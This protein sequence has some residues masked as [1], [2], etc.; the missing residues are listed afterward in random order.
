[1]T[2]EYEVRPVPSNL[3]L[4]TAAKS[5]EPGAW[6]YEID[7]DYPKEQVTPPEA[8]RGGW[9]V[10]QDG[11]LTGRYA[12]NA[13]YRAI[14]QSDRVLKPYMYVGARSFKSQWIVD[15]DPRGEHLFPAIPD[16]LIRGW[17]Y[18]DGEGHITGQ[19]RPSSRWVDGDE[20]S[21]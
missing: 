2:G 10:G 21:S 1:M 4:L 7:W 18:V 3:K 13:R 14:Q 19:F 5:A 9:E 8:I 6:V 15:V 20:K 16:H 11:S 12:P 17:W